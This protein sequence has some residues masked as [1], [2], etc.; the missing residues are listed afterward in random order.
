MAKLIRALTRKKRGT[1]KRG[2]I[3]ALNDAL[4]Q[5][6]Q[7]LSV[8]QGAGKIGIMMMLRAKRLRKWLL[9]LKRRRLRLKRRL[10]NLEALEKLLKEE[11]ALA[12]ECS[13]AFQ[14]I[15]EPTEKQ[16]AERE[17]DDHPLNAQEISALLASFSQS[18]PKHLEGSK[19]PSA[20]AL[21]KAGGPLL[22]KGAKRHHPQA[23]R[24][25]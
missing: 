16:A 1:K 2:L 14:W 19:N 13:M 17:P 7:S 9:W 8:K 25:G 23:K 5:N 21:T 24:S 10:Q 3:Q 11:M 18:T 4:H 6:D 20:I 12:K 22:D 15:T